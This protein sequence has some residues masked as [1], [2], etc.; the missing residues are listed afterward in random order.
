MPCADQ[1]PE[2]CNQLSAPLVLSR[3]DVESE[4]A[5]EDVNCSSLTLYA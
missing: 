5:P 1:S 3:L 4:E 2:C